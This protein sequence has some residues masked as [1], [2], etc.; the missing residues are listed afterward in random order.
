MAIQLDAFTHQSIQIRSL[1]KAVM[2]ADVAPAKVVYDDEQD[3]RSRR[4][5]H[6]R[7]IP[8]C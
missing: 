1:A 5:A 3:V 4:H 2:P 7:V 6:G 8:D